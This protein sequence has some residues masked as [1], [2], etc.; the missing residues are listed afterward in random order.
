MCCIISIAVVLRQYLEYEISLKTGFNQGIVQ[1]RVKGG[2]IL[3]FTDV[4]SS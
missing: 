2:S 3:L 1:V 4:I